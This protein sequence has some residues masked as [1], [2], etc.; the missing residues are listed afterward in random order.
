V[1]VRARVAGSEPTDSVVGR[2]ARP[3][4]DGRTSTLG[5]RT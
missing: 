5:G 4:T 1:G 2:P 3:L